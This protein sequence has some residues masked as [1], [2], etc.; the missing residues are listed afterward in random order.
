[1]VET[2][3]DTSWQMFV[4]LQAQPAD[5]CAEPAASSAVT[6]P[7]RLPT[8]LSVQDVMVEAR[9]LNRVCPKESAWQ[10]LCAR[11]QNGAGVEPPP[12]ILAPEWARTPPL[13]KRTRLRDQVEWCEE[14]GLLPLVYAYLKSLAEEDWS[15]MKA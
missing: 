6:Q 2:S 13:V 4:S 1:V 3:S 7:V 5:S 11:L 9:R 14:R 15:H 12:P 10:D 8:S